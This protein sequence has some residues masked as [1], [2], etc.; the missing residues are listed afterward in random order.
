MKTAF[1][2]FCYLPAQYF[3]SNFSPKVHRA[4]YDIDYSKFWGVLNGAAWQISILL[5]QGMFISVS[6][7]MERVK[8]LRKSI[9][10]DIEKYEN[11]C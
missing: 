8:K 10:S 2:Y 1:T 5:M 6:A 7:I 4:W 11:I 3:H 9:P